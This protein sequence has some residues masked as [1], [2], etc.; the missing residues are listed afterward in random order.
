MRLETISTVS[1]VCGTGR[2]APRFPCAVHGCLPRNR[3]SEQLAI[4]REVKGKVSAVGT[5]VIPAP[6]QED[7]HEFKATLVIDRD[8]LH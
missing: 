1:P 8:C 5:L 6:R 3:P 7:C 4:G 2:T